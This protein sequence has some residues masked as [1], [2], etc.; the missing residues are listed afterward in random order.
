MVP[1][2]FSAYTSALGGVRKKVT[3]SHLNCRNNFLVLKLHWK[4]SSR[5]WTQLHPFPCLC[6]GFIWPH[7][8][9]RQLANPNLLVFCQ[10]SNLNC[11]GGFR[12]DSVCWEYVAVRRN[13]CLGWRRKYLFWHQWS[14]YQL[15]LSYF[16]FSLLFSSELLCVKRKLCCDEVRA[17]S[18]LRQRCVS[19]SVAEFGSHVL[20]PRGFS[21]FLLPLDNLEWR[22][23]KGGQCS[24]DEYSAVEWKCSW[25]GLSSAPFEKE[26]YSFWQI[27]LDQLGV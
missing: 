24:L 20:L 3:I 6:S 11:Y 1:G 18:S 25:N 8:E 10:V 21:P 19:G 9:L 4:C 27:R 14:L 16:D 12:Q 13:E 15:S 26:E 17:A 2:Y 5:S 23:W 7:G 22:E